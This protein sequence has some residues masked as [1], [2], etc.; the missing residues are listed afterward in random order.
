MAV[1]VVVAFFGLSALGRWLLERM[2]DSTDKQVVLILL[3]IAVAGFGA[4][5]I[6]LEPIIGAFLAGLAINRAMSHGQAKEQLEFLGN[7]LF[8]PMFFVSIGFLIDV[9]LFWQ[10]LVGRIGLVVGIVGG[11]IAAKYLAAYLTQRL[12]G[13]SPSQRRLIWSLSLPQVAATLATAIVAYQCKNAEGVRLI[14]EPMINT[15]LVL[16]VITSLL[17][18]VLTEIAAGQR[19]LEQCAAAAKVVVVVPPQTAPAVA[20]DRASSSITASPAARPDV[21][22]PE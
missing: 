1:Y 7:T 12:Y 21:G 6:N 10:T 14:D 20:G 4:E 18:P 9:E 2:G 11:L 19:L 8:I 22:L 17:G 5:A 13:Y 16:V 15:V 3:I